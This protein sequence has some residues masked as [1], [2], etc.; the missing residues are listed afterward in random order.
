[1]FHEPVRRKGSQ[2]SYVE[3]DPGDM[4][5]LEKRRMS[6]DD[7]YMRMEDLQIGWKK[8]SDQPIFNL[9]ENHETQ[10]NSSVSMPTVIKHS[11]RKNNFLHTDKN[12]GELQIQERHFKKG[13]THKDDYAFLDFEQK[14]DYV[15]MEKA[16]TKKWQFPDFNSNK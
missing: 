16:K 3:M 10:H 5:S 7:P 4:S 6:E 9:E 1:M 15:D 2:S 13:N 14:K 12:K 8:A 11:K